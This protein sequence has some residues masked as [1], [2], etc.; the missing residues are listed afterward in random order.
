MPTY[1]QN[2]PP[3]V[4]LQVPLAAGCASAT[5]QPWFGD[6]YVTAASC[7]SGDNDGWKD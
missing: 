7:G 4:S 5:Y 6:T 2:V 3:G 1:V